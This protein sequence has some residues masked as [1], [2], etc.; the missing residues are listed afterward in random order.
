[1]KIKIIQS[2]NISDELAKDGS[3]ELTSQVYTGSG[4][5]VTGAL[6]SY[7]GANTWDSIPH[8]SSPLR[9]LPQPM[10]LKK[11]EMIVFEPIFNSNY[12]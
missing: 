5:W 10:N 4:A 11:N 2:K 6:N 7:T 8:S 1:M 12:E 9:N 3:V